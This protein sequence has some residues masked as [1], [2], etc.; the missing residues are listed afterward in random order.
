LIRKFVRPVFKFF[1]TRPADERNH[2]VYSYNLFDRRP[3]RPGASAMRRPEQYD[4][5]SGAEHFEKRHLESQSFLNI[6]PKVIT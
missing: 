4:R 2:V 5:I 3:S 1:Y 6:P